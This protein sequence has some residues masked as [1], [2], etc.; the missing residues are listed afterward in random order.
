MPIKIPSQNDRPQSPLP[1]LIIEKVQRRNY[2]DEPEEFYD[3]LQVTAQRYIDRLKRKGSCESRTTYLSSCSDVVD[4]DIR[5]SLLDSSCERNMDQVSESDKQNYDIDRNSEEIRPEEISL[6]D[7]DI[8]SEDDNFHKTSTQ[9]SDDS[10]LGNCLENEINHDY[11]KLYYSGS[12]DEVTKNKR[13]NSSNVI[14]EQITC[15]E[16]DVEEDEMFPA[17]MKSPILRNRKKLFE[18]TGSGI[19]NICKYLYSI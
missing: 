18:E 3:L 14:T 7:C 6:D 9:S 10:E 8:P 11:Y 4:D 15:N 16:D 17:E 5:S 2:H 13:N 12:N 1:D 19:K